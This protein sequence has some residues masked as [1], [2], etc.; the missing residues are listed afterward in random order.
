MDSVQ[1]YNFAKVHTIDK[2]RIIQNF[3][4]SYEKQLETPA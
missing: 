3:M 1:R 2:Q 4:H